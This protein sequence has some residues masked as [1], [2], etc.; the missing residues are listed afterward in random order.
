MSFFSEDA[1]LF[2]R[3]YDVV[4]AMKA[5]W[6]ADL[7]RFFDA[8]HGAVQGRVGERLSRKLPAGYRYW[9]LEPEASAVGSAMLWYFREYPELIRD[10][11]LIWYAYL[12]V[13][14]HHA[15]EVVQAS[16]R[17][18]AEPGLRSV[19][20]LSFELGPPD[21]FKPLRLLFSWKQDPVVELAEPV[22]RT[23]QV[24]RQAASGL[25]RTD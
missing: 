14:G 19:S 15:A 23:L 1:Q 9:W 11:K 16:W 25:S 21:Q 24:L 6:E 18:L 22:A 10:R 5:A 12:E 8:L 3:E 7:Q 13:Q 20:G 2:S 4:E 17:S